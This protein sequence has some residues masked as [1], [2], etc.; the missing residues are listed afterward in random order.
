MTLPVQ[1][2]FRNLPP[3]ARLTA[4]VHDRAAKLGTF[5]GRIQGCRVAIEAPHTHQHHGFHYRVRVDLMVPGAELVAGHGDHPCY[6][7]PYAAVNGAFKHAER[8][9]KSHAERQRGRAA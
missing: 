3:S 5:F 2:T 1:V 7:D 9:L 8:L 6:E 4:H